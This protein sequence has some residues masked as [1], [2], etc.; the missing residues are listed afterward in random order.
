MAK[1]ITHTLEIPKNATRWWIKKSHDDTAKKRRGEDRLEVIVDNYRKS[2]NCKIEFS[3][4][5][6]GNG[7]VRLVIKNSFQNQADLDGYL[8]ILEPYAAEM[9]A[10][11]AEANITSIDTITEE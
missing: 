7:K 9:D 10:Y 8:A 3:S 6:L 5:Q 11:H 1:I 2:K 4:T